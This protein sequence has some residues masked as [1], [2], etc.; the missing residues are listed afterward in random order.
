VSLSA[1]YGWLKKFPE[2]QK[3]R[4]FL[5]DM[6]KRVFKASRGTYGAERICGV[7]RKAGKKCSF[8]K[9]RSMMVGGGLFSIYNRYHRW[10]VSLTDS[11]RARV[12]L[13][14][15]HAKNIVVKEPYELLTSDIT[16]IRTDKGYAYL[17]A[18]KDVFSGLVLS[19]VM[20]ERMT[21]E[22]VIN[23]V[24]GA[25]LRYTIPRGAIFHSD[26]GSQYTSL[27]VGELLKDNGIVQSFSAVGK[28]GDNSWSESFFSVFKKE[29]V[30]WSGRKSFEEWKLDVFEYIEVFYNTQREQ[31]R[32]GYMTPREFLNCWIKK[33]SVGVA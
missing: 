11:S 21:K 32:L 7:L 2:R 16:Y 1:Y 26:R 29:K 27:A 12:G 4:G 20:S 28:P 10:S 17:C 33:N 5:A 23:A 30:H 3:E 18:V 9:V 24:M 25:V 8:R 15:N 14:E 31:K 6:I 22:I 13:Y 19:Q